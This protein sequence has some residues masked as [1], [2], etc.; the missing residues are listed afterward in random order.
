MFIPTE[1]LLNE[2][3]HRVP[4]LK[5]AEIRQMVNAFNGPESFTPD[6][7]PFLGEAPEVTCNKKWTIAAN[8]YSKIMRIFYLQNVLKSASVK[9]GENSD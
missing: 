6:G 4:A 3:L 5:K 7:L 9:P 2:M 1:P 8:I